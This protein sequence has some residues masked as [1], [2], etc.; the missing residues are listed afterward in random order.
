[1]TRPVPNLSSP[2]VNKAGKVATPW[3]IWFQQ[4]SEAPEA[5]QPV[6]VG[7]SPFSFQPNDFGTMYVVGGTV[8]NIEFIRGGT[9]ISIPGVT[10]RTIPMSPKDI[11]RVTYSVLPTI[12]FV[13]Q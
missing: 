1:M 3:N 10:N 9:T 5:I 4:F 13:P 8:S 2:L 11:V 7:A 6:S 12:S